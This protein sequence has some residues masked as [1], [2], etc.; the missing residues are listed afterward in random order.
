M[1]KSRAILSTKKYFNNDENLPDS[2]IKNVF[3]GTFKELFPSLS[4]KWL[5]LWNSFK[6]CAHGHSWKFVQ[7]WWK[8]PY[9]R[10]LYSLFGLGNYLLGGVDIYCKFAANKFCIHLQIKFVLTFRH[11]LASIAPKPM[12]YGRNYLYLARHSSWGRSAMTLQKLHLKLRLW[13]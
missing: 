9:R 5:T 1:I 6:C 13:R 10:W 7:R 4:I 12:L 3:L 11:V 2:I 8:L